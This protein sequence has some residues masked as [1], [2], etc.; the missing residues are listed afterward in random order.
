[1]S[2]KRLEP[3]EEPTVRIAVVGATLADSLLPEI[4]KAGLPEGCEIISLEV[5]SEEIEECIH[6]LHAIGFKGVAISHPHKVAAARLAQRFFSVKH[7]MGVANALV[8]EGGIWGQNNEVASIQSLLRDVEPNTALLLG[9]G[10]GARSV[11]VALLDAGWKVRLWN[12][13][14]MRSRLLQSTIKRFGEIDLV[15]NAN[16]TG[17]TLIVNATSV[18]RRAGEKL[19]VDWSY[20]RRGTTVMDLVYR[21]VPTELLREAGLRGLRTIDGRHIV[22]E[23]AALSLEWWLGHPV[24]RA[25]LL[26]AAGL[27][28]PSE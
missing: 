6:H 21:R 2:W 25:P 4:L 15:P 16:P 3:T 5:T 14:G 11:A 18:G 28:A 13:N 22:A 23:K 10:S 1:M 19:P 7:A 20:V 24:D 27:R 8:F 12:R 26:L 9:A 17:C